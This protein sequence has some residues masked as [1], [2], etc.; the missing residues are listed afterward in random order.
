MYNWEDCWSERCC[1]LQKIGPSSV[2]NYLSFTV[3]TPPMPTYPSPSFHSLYNLGEL[4]LSW[5]VGLRQ[6]AQAYL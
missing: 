1:L 3:C 6:V 2:G 4:P 5:P